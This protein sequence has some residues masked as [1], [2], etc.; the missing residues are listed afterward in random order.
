MIIFSI[1]IQNGNDDF[2]LLY[3]YAAAKLELNFFNGSPRV[4]GNNISADIQTS[5]AVVRM[6]C[7]LTGL[8]YQDCK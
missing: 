4:N 2:F 1:Y 5:R 8:P 6:R 3:I 7:A